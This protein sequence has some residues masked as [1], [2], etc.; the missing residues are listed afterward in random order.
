MIADV[1]VEIGLV[2]PIDRDEQDVPRRAVM[3]VLVAEA[4]MG[5]GGTGYWDRDCGRDR[6]R[7]RDRG[8]RNEEPAPSGDAPAASAAPAG[9]EKR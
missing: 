4:R 2:K 6:D 8:R 5:E 1:P 7:D 3:G 9:D